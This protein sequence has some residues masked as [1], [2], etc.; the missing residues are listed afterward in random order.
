MKREDSVYLEENKK[1]LEKNHGRN[2]NDMLRLSDDMRNQSHSPRKKQPG[3]NRSH[4]VRGRARTICDQVSSDDRETP[5]HG[6][7]VYKL[8]EHVERHVRMTP[9]NL[10][11]DKDGLEVASPCVS[12]PAEYLLQEV[13]VVLCEGEAN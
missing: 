10:F 1:V 5:D 11:I 4:H 13:H 7:R 12:S 6:Y 2:I 3:N 8:V 9:K